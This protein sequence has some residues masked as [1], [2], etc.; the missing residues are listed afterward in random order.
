MNP[1]KLTVAIVS[2][3]ALAALL[4]GAFI[5]HR[6]A[7][8]SQELKVAE[9]AARLVRMHSPVLGPQ[10][11]P[12]TIVEFF[13]PACETC[14]AFY[15]VVKNLLRKHPAEVRLVIRYAPFHQGSDK[16]VKLLE[17]SKLQ[18]KY[19]PV[20][21]MVL[22]SQ[23]MWADHANPNVELAYK[24]AER[25]GLDIGRALADAGTPAMEAVLR[26]DVEDLTTLQVTKTPTFFVNGRALPSF[27]AEQLT[28]LVEEEVAKAKK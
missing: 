5:Y 2:G 18:G 1:R 23:P 22:A 25:A 19:W 13:D 21:E 28:A 26:Q 9:Q 15:P 14:R 20:L 8:E 6:G 27:G 10:N 16:V 12:V 4:V 17:A 11:A 7:Q 3:I 24:A